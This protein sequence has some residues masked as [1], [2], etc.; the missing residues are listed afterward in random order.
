VLFRSFSF[1][2]DARARGAAVSIVLGDAR[3][4]MQNARDESFDAIVLDAYSSDVVPMHLLTREALELYWKKL[5]P[6]GFMLM[7]IS[8][9]Y[10]DLGRVV[11]AH[12]SDEKIVCLER[13]DEL[14]TEDDRLAR[15]RDGKAVS[16]WILLSRHDLPPHGEKWHS[17]GEKSRV[18]TDDY[19]SILSV[20]RF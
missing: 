9:R 1:V 10:L 7:N 4:Q 18:W 15:D 11:S 13:L 8:N 3:L 20:V 2:A 17:L 6:G 16:R 5:A 12:C 14:E 19:A